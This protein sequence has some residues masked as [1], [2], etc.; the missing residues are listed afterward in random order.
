MRPAV[1]V[2]APAA[3]LTARSVLENK[4]AADHPTAPEWRVIPSFPDYEASRCGAIR[5]A[6]PPRGRQKAYGIGYI[7]KQWQEP[8][9]YWVV[10]MPKD[11]KVRNKGC[12]ASRLIA[13]AF[14]GPAPSP[15]HHAAHNDGDPTNNAASNLRWATARE[16]IG[17]KFLHGTMYQGERHHRARLS[18]TE[19]TAIRARRAAGARAK[20][21]AAEYGVSSQL[22]TAIVKRVCWRHVP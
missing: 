15:D 14:H 12:R 8:H 22:I 7:L 18:G 6:T 17:D 19:A 21:L 20:D 10:A 3:S 2:D 11:G 5:R 4:M 1:G 9:G 13:E 16:N